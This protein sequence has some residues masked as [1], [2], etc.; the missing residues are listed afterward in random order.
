MQAEALVLQPD[1]P[2]FKFVGR[3]WKFVVARWVQ[4][5]MAVDF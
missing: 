4:R 3:N 1:F 5:N 2:E